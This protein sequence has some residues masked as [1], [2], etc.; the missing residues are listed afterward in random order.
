QSRPGPDLVAIQEHKLRGTA[1]TSIGQRLWRHA[2]A[3]CLAVSP[4]Y[5]HHLDTNGAGQG[6]VLTLLHPR[7]QRNIRDSGSIHD[8]K[9][10]WTILTG[11]PRDDIG[12]ANVYAPND[13]LSRCL[14]WEEIARTLSRTCRWILMGDYYMVEQR[15]DKSRHCHTLMPSRERVLFDVLKDTLQIEEHPRSSQSLKFS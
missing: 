9:V 6:G 1:V 15:G 13:S 5:G 3:F 14:L 11:I 4:G 12:F 10:Q 2:P 7:W 8:N